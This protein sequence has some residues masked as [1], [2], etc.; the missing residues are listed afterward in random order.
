[1]NTASDY[2]KN[3]IKLGTFFPY[4]SMIGKLVKYN[5]VLFC[6]KQQKTLPIIIERWDV[7]LHSL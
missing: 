1:M 3:K 6:P 5:I 4:P 7:I 2:K